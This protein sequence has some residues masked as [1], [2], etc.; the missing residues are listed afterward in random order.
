MK[1]LD[2][3]AGRENA[4]IADFL[5]KLGG[6]NP[7][8]YPNFR[9]VESDKILEKKGGNWHDWDESL[10]VEER[11]A[12]IRK[13][14]M[15]REEQVVPGTNGK[16]VEVEVEKSIILPGNVPLRVVAE[17]REIPKYSHLD[18]QGWILEK[19]Y[20]AYMFGSQED[21]YSHLVPGTTIPRLGPYPVDGMYEMVAGVFPIYPPLSF[22]EQ[23]LAYH[24]KKTRERQETDVRA[25]VNEA[26]HRH[27]LEEEK[28]RADAEQRIKDRL[29]LLTG[30]SLEAGRWRNEQAERAGIRS[31]M[32]N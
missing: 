29:T 28:K 3:Y 6:K 11:A 20:P 17:I 4:V 23:F 16:P 15:V 1:H 21:W 7:A 12:T 22:L 30:T 25:Y 18:T 13:T 5:I 8:G 31:H 2:G 9:L 19:Y 26:L 32:G 10:A 14:F 24:A 27:E